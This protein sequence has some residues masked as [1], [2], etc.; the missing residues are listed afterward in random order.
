MYETQILLFIATSLLV[1]LTPGQDMV[2]V[3]S[4]GITQGARAGMITAAGV[5]I[6]LLGHTVLASLGVGA[7]L[8]AS[9]TLFTLVKVIGASCIRLLVI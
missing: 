2:I 5:S 8:M 7:V 3:M 9:G 6:G 1:I 4:R